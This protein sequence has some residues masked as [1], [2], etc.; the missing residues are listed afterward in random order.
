MM[1]TDMR[2]HPE[3]GTIDSQIDFYRPFGVDN[4]GSVF[5]PITGTDLMCPEVFLETDGTLDILGKWEAMSG[6]SNQYGY[7]GPMMHAS[8]Y[9]SGSGME[10]WIRANPGVYVVTE[11]LDADNLDADD[12]GTMTWVLLKSTI[13]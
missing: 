4:D 9:M 6:F 2:A 10:A 3:F 7:R 1:S 5:G 8:E 13:V 12:P 11:P